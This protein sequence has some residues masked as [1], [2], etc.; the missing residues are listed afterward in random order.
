MLEIITLKFLFLERDNKYLLQ[1]PFYCW[2]TQIL[3]FCFLVCYETRWTINPLL[4]ACVWCNPLLLACSMHWTWKWLTTVW[5]CT[6]LPFWNLLFLADIWKD[7]GN[8][9]ISDR[10]SA[11]DQLLQSYIFMHVANFRYDYLETVKL[12]FRCVPQGFLLY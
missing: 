1:L 2:M 10:I 5:I 7:W 9:M 12:I 8:H 4:L 3:M 11:K 6:E